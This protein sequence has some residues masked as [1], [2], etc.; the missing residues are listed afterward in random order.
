[1]VSLG[2]CLVISSGVRAAEAERGRRQASRRGIE[3]SSVR[4]LLVAAAHDALAEEG[5][6]EVMWVVPAGVL[7]LV[8]LPRDSLFVRCFI[9]R[10]H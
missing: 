3:F 9:W 1:M 5:E 4:V 7:R 10:G 6:Q 8:H 2:A